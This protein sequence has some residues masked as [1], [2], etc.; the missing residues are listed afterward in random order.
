M[1]MGTSN[2]GSAT[3][4]LI[5]TKQGALNADYAYDACIIHVIAA[6]SGRSAIGCTRAQRES[7]TSNTA[8]VPL[9]STV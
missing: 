1:R 5:S 9:L 4:T 6:P 2:L 7:T 8:T 3:G